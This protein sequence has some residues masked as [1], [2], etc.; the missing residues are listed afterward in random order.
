MTAYISPLISAKGSIHL[1]L[2][3]DVPL[4]VRVRVRDLLQY[5]FIG[6]SDVR[7][8][9][10]IRIN[11]GGRSGRLEFEYNPGLWGVVCTSSGFNDDAADAA[12]SQLGYVRSIDIFALNARSV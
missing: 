1:R 7:I 5:Y 3:I 8:N 9:G 4:G 2:M 11:G 10:D 6:C 12:C